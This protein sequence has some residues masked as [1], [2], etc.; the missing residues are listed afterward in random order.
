[1]ENIQKIAQERISPLTVEFEYSNFNEN[2]GKLDWGFN[3]I[4]KEA[5]KI[6]LLAYVF[7]SGLKTLYY[8]I[9]N[10][11]TS[12]ELLVKQPVFRNKNENWVLGWELMP[13]KYQ[14]W[15]GKN[16]YDM[17]EELTSDAFESSEFY[18]TIINSII[19]ASE[20]FKI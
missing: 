7:E 17:I 8:G 5:N 4:I 6:V 15:N 10:Q 9:P 1:M 12:H 2:G 20:L 16:L 19:R 13:I 14:Y 3:Y 18:K 11:G